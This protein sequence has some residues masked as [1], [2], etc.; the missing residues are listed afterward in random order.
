VAV[1]RARK[2]DGE[3]LLRDE[4]SY[5]VVERCYRVLEKIS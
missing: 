1:R 3:E 4:G 5:E 2:K